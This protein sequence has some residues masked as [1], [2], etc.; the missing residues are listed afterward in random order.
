MTESVP[1]PTFHSPTAEE[2]EAAPEYPRVPLFS[3][4]ERTFYVENR[5]RP[6]LSYG[7]MR[8]LREEGQAS[9][10]AWMNEKLLGRDALIALEEYDDMTTEENEALSE[11]LRSIAMGG[12]SVPKD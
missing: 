9:A 10:E 5:A 1:A 6:A 8:R 4:D 12:G 2:R 3:I 11:R 7:Y